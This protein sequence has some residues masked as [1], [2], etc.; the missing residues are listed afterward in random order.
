M[1]TFLIDSPYR[2]FFLSN[3]IIR[4]KYILPFKEIVTE[5]PDFIQLIIIDI[6]IT[7]V[8]SIHTV[9]NIYLDYP[10]F[11]PINRNPHKHILKQVL[12]KIS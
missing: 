3:N 9:I 4:K 8:I 12:I 6:V 7:A 11:S 5:Y 1:P 10:I 2:Y